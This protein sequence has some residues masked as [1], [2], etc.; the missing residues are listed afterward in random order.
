MDLVKIHQVF[1]FD[2]IDGF[3]KT[4]AGVFIRVPGIG[5]FVET[6]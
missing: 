5:N 3:D 6:H 4:I 2:G 1:N